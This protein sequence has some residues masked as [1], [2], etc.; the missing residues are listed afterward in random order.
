M[1]S[2][3]NQSTATMPRRDG[4]PTGE[5][6]SAIKEEVVVERRSNP[7]VR[8]AGLVVVAILVVAALM[9]GIRY[10]GYARAHQSTDDAHVDANTVA[11]T[12][13]ISE[14]IDRIY[15]DTGAPVRKGQL[16]ISL[17]GT[18][19]NARVTQAQ[20]NLQ[21]AIETQ[22]ALGQ[23]SIGGIEQARASV[24]SAAAQV[25]VAQAGVGAAQ[26]QV[27]AAQAQVPGAAQALARAQADFNRTQSLVSSGDIP[28][29]QL[30]SARAAQAAA[31]SQ[32]RATSDNV[33]VAISNLQAAE[34]RVPASQA[35]IGAAQGGV[36]QAQGKLTQAEAPA[37]ISAQRAALDIARQQ[38]RY[39]KIYA[40]SDGYI[41]ER[42]VEVG[43]TVQPGLP[44]LTL[45]P[46]RV[47][48]TANFKETQLGSMRPGQNVDLKIDAYKGQVFH[49]KVLSI[50]PASQ[51]TYAL[52]PAQNSTGNFVK[53]TQRVPVKIS[54]D[55]ADPRRFPLRPG[56]S[57]EASVQVR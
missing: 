37:Q 26:A 15:V 29:A 33:N 21:L 25:P 23:Q 5:A 42:S 46:N 24:S 9:W 8:T 12:S 14:R 57:V 6:S 10:F 7:A 2:G 3:D 40:P 52:V 39:T 47:F 41:G 36:T 44:L 30:D 22:S 54:V 28:R 50:N 18:D 49:G 4:R 16:L 31:A 1:E 55:D 56:M 51:N 17:D 27:Q 13:K 45:I 34:A 11:V 19:E 43:Q 38:L 53:V 32:N 35:G 48:V 20:A